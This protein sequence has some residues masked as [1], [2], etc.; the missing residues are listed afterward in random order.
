MKGPSDFSESD[1]RF[2]FTGDWVL[3]RYDTHRYYKGWSG[4]GLKGVDFIGILDDA[5]LVLIEVKNY[6]FRSGGR[7]GHTLDA[8]RSDSSILTEDFG[9]KIVD[10]FTAIDA[11]RQYWQRHWWR[12]L[13]WRRSGRRKP[14]SSE[15]AFWARICALAENPANCILVLWLESEDID[16]VFRQ[17]IAAQ[18]S[19]ELAAFAATVYVADSKTNPLEAHIEARPSA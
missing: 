18:L 2:R 13:V 1:L 8:I 9:H 10:T 19:E 3:Y 7:R 11:V 4:S 5:T 6:G 12:R 14:E 17:R 16:E 15:T